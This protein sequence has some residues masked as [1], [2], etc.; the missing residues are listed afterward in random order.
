MRPSQN[1]LEARAVELTL[2]EIKAAA[3][4]RNQRTLIL[5]ERTTVCSAGARHGTKEEMEAFARCELLL[6]G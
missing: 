6:L 5:R 3:L 4:V 1:A 2:T